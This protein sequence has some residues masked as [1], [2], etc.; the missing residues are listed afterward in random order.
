MGD[1]GIR[2]LDPGICLFQRARTT[3]QARK[4]RK[5]G[6]VREKGRGNRACM[7]WLLYEGLMFPDPSHRLRYFPIMVLAASRQWMLVLAAPRP[8]IL[9]LAAPRPSILILNTHCR[10][11]LSQAL[12]FVGHNS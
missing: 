9:M 12:I 11:S 5:G 10:S 3:A 6:H 1:C 4:A 7:T 2:P 8:S